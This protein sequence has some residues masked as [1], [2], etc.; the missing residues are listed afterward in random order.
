MSA[1]FTVDE[2]GVQCAY[3]LDGQD[4]V[5]TNQSGFSPPSSRFPLITVSDLDDKEHNLTIISQ[6][7][8][9]QTLWLD[10]LS[11]TG[12]SLPPVP[13]SSS[14]VI[15]SNSTTPS[16]HG[17]SPGVIVAIVLGALFGVA[18]LAFMI[19]YA[20]RRW[21][22]LRIARPQQDLS[23]KERAFEITPSGAGE[24]SSLH[25]LIITVV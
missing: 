21:H 5:A 20:S 10:S 9:G 18:I 4:L 7:A 13:P 24:S 14:P 11:F 25:K 23:S 17:I 19:F 8:P 3:S 16:R 6:V 2:N 22:R 12:H 1:S 15:L